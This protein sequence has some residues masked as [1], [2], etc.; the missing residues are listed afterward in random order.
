MIKVFERIRA[1][2][3]VS[4]GRD[5]FGKFGA[6]GY[7]LQ[8]ASLQCTAETS[9]RGEVGALAAEEAGLSRLSQF[10]NSKDGAVG[11]RVQ[12]SVIDYTSRRIRVQVPRTPRKPDTAVHDT[13]ARS[14]NSYSEAG[15]R[16]R[17]IPRGLR[18]SFPDIH[19]N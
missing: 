9:V 13:V 15:G 7:K 1:L 16:H 18:T 17:R 11:E 19:I 5:A 2:G 8:L 14:C 3:L 12:G 6:R 4:V 10:T